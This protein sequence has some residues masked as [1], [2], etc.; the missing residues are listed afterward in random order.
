MKHSYLQRVHDERQIA[1]NRNKP[2]SPV[3]LTYVDLQKAPF[4]FPVAHQTAARRGQ[5]GKVSVGTGRKTELVLLEADAE[6]SGL[7][8]LQVVGFK[9]HAPLEDKVDAEFLNVLQEPESGRLFSRDI[10][11]FLALSRSIKRVCFFSH[12]KGTTIPNHHECQRRNKE[13]SPPGDQG[14]CCFSSVFRWP[15]VGRSNRCDISVRPCR[16][17]GSPPKTEW[18]NSGGP[19]PWPTRSFRSPCTRWR[20]PV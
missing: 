15:V 3:A 14:H 6:P 4:R 18:W 2:V 16:S 11:N 17:P 13:A 12:K 5:P 20:P 8:L 7:W 9:T 10:A 1:S 19:A